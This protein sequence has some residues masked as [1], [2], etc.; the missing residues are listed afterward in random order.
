MVIAV[1]V[2]KVLGSMF[3]QHRLF[4][5]LGEEKSLLDMHVGE[6][7]IMCGPY[8]TGHLLYRNDD[9]IV[10]LTDHTTW[11]ARYEPCNEE[12]VRILGKGSAVT[13]TV[14]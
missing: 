10:S 4:T 11:E 2:L 6:L 3:N 12:R 1:A 8:K 14:N 5:H 9:N 7:G 13:L